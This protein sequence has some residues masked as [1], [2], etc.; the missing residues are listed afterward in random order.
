MFPE[1]NI[2]DEGRAAWGRLQHHERTSWADWVRLGHA[3]LIGRRD[4]MLTAKANSPFGVPYVKAIGAWL[5]ENGLDGI[6]GQDRY[7]IIQCLEHEHDIEAWRAT[8]TEVQRLRWNHPNSIWMHFSRDFAPG[9]Q[10]EPRKS[11][12][13]ATRPAPKRQQIAERVTEVARR[14]GKPIFWPQDF[15]RRAH[16]AMLASRSTDLLTLA[17]LALQAAIRSE[18]D[19]LALLDDTP[20]LPADADNADAA[21]QAA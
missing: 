17:R 8:L 20:G 13:A 21:H 14:H 12:A 5:R 4:A 2:I 18:D 9:P 11:K 10:V 3:I 7:K 15:M 16:E 6:N 19:L 1:Q